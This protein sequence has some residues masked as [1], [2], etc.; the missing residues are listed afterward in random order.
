VKVTRETQPDIVLM[1]ICMPVMDGITAA[2][3]ITA[4]A[5]MTPYVVAH[6]L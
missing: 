3:I 1:D 4:V 5:A 2:E 6:R